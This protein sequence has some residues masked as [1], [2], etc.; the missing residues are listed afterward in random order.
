[1]YDLIQYSAKHVSLDSIFCFLLM[2]LVVFIFTKRWDYSLFVG[3]CVMILCITLVDRD[4]F[5]SMVYRTNLFWSY[6]HPEEWTQIVGN[7]VMFIPIGVFGYMCLEHRVLIFGLAFSICIEFAQLILRRG[8]CEFDD[9][10][11]NFVGCLLGF[12]VC[13]GAKRVCVGNSVVKEA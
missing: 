12:L 3:Y 4:I 1:M 2:F 11:G 6:T 13:Y 10:F 5:S 7:I 8:V 9:V